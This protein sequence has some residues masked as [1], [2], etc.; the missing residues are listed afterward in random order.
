VPTSVKSAEHVVHCAATVQES[1]LV[2]QAEI[3]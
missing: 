1:Q 2:A 3:G